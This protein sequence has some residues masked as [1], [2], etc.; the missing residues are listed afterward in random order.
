[1]LRLAV[2]LIVMVAGVWAYLAGTLTPQV[3]NDN[4]NVVQA[5]CNYSHSITSG[6]WEDACGLAQN[7]SGEQYQCTTC[8][9]AI[10]GGTATYDGELQ[11]AVG[12]NFVQPTGG[13]EQ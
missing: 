8:S 13:N 7:V 9:P 11:P 12:I 5:I 3:Y 10:I 1:M 6:D 4:G 2:I